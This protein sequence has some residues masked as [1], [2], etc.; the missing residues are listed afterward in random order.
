M[1]QFPSLNYK[2][3]VV[4]FNDQWEPKWPEKKVANFYIWP[5]VGTVDAW[6]GWWQRSYLWKEIFQ[7]LGLL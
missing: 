3:I 6:W 1:T 7:Q 4:N 5:F 2:L